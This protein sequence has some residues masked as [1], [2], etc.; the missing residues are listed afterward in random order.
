MLLRTLGHSENP[1][2]YKR[3]EM[4]KPQHIAGPRYFAD[5]FLMAETTID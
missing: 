3:S 5:S 1:L 2:F 4:V